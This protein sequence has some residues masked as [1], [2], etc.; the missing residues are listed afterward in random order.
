M[1]QQ[2]RIC[3]C[4]KTKNPPY[5]DHSHESLETPAAKK[6]LCT[7]GKTKTPPYCDH[8]H[9]SLET[10]AA[11]KVLCTCGKTKTPP[12]CDHSHH[13]LETPA[14]KKVLCTCGKT[15][16]PPYCDHSHEGLKACPVKIT[17]VPDK[18]LLLMLPYW[19]PL[20]PPQGISQLKTYLQKHG[21]IIKT[22]D[23]NAKE[24]FKRFYNRYFDVFRKYI[25]ED[26]QGN[27]FNIG[28]E[29]MRNHMMAHINYENEAEYTELVKTIIYNTFYTHFDDGQVM[30]L[31]RLLDE[32]YKLLEDYILHLLIEERPAVLGISVLQDTVGPALFAFKLTKERY[33]FIKT[34]MGGGVFA[35]THAVGTPNFEILLEKTK[36]IKNN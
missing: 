21:Y 12:Y 32:F 8:S 2:K 17:P 6:V 4:G 1:A 5:C 15:K 16:T 27:F 23:A 9:H 30:E 33:P 36:Y 3:T 28:H 11:K 31:K 20:I 24:E 25:P 22:G 19:D 26:K 10:P 34:V 13:S 18:I 29:I 14:A 35:D 7:C